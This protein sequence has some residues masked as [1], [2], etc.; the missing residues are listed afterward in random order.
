MPRHTAL[1]ST[2]HAT[3]ARATPTSRSAITT[4]RSDNQTSR[5]DD[6]TSRSAI[7]TPRSDNPTRRAI[8]AVLAAIPWL[9]SIDLRAAEGGRFRVE[10]VVYDAEDAEHPVARSLT[11]FDNGVAWDFLDAL[12]EE[13]HPRAAE[14][15]EIVLHDPARGRVVLVDP[16]RNVK[17]R[18]ELVRLERLRASLAAWAK[19]SDDTLLRWA[20]DPGIAEKATEEGRTIVLAG[21]RVRY[22]VRHEPAPCAGAAADYR[23][24]AD[25]ALLIKALL[26]PG[27]IPPFPRSAIN[28]RVAEADALPASVRLSIESRLGRIGAP[29]TVSRSEHRAIESWTASD[30][31]RVATAGERLSEAEEVDLA[32]YAGSAVALDAGAETTRR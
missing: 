22:E 29:P 4:P 31:K 32:A 10:T 17:T 9:W 11:L 16:A 19:T 23:R 18:V 27:G 8:L 6:T 5:S 7:T 1:P 2:G 28:A 13:G 30:H 12:D 26:H 24:F 3:A 20:G 25:T 21:P 15:A 14:P